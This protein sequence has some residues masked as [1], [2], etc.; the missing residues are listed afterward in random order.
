MKLYKSRILDLKLSDINKSDAPL[1]GL[2]ALFFHISVLKNKGRVPDL[3]FIFQQQTFCNISVNTEARSLKFFVELPSSLYNT[4]VSTFLDSGYPVFWNPA[5]TCNFSNFCQ[6]EDA[7][8]HSQ[9][10]FP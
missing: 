9:R 5:K 6:I 2:L 8:F 7:H 1:A 10:A 4:L 3:Y